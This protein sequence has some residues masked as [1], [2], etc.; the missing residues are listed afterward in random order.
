M[1]LLIRLIC[2]THSMSGI[3]VRDCLIKSKMLIKAWKHWLEN[4]DDCVA[5]SA[6][7]RAVEIGLQEIEKN[8]KLYKFPL[9]RA[10][11]ESVLPHSAYLPIDHAVFFTKVSAELKASD[12]LYRFSSPNVEYNI[13]LIEIDGS[14]TGLLAIAKALKDRLKK[15]G[16]RAQIVCVGM[17]DPTK[18]CIVL[19]AHNLQAM[20]SVFRTLYLPH[21][22]VIYNT[23]PLY[24]GNPYLQNPL[25]VLL[26][27][28][29]IWDTSFSSIAFLKEHGVS[30]THHV[31]I[32][33]EQGLID[34]KHM[35][36]IVLKNWEKT[37]IPEKEVQVLV[38]GRQTNRTM[39]VLLQLYDAGVRVKPI[40][41]LSGKYRNAAYAN[42]SILLYIHPMASNNTF[43][44]VLLGHAVANGHF[45]VSETSAEVPMWAG[46]GRVSFVEYD[47]L[48]KQVIWI[49]KNTTC[50]HRFRMAKTVR[51]EFMRT[52][53]YGP[54]LENWIS[55]HSTFSLDRITK[56]KWAALYVVF[57][58]DQWLAKSVESIYP[59]VDGILFL[60]GYYNFNNKYECNEKFLQ[61][62]RELPD[63]DHKIIGIYR[64]G[65]YP[66]TEERNAGIEM[67]EKL[68]FQFTYTIDADELL[69]T[70]D[71]K[72]IQEVLET[73][74]LNEVYVS[75]T[76]CYWKSE[77]YRIDPP[78]PSSQFL[79]GLRLHQGIKFK[80]IR[81]TLT[82]DGYHEI[83]HLKMH[84]MS[85]ARS[86][87]QVKKK[88][89]RW[90][91]TADL[92]PDWFD[93][94]WKAWD[95]DHSMENLHPTNPELYKRVIPVP[96]DELP[97][98]L[99]LSQDS[100][101]PGLTVLKEIS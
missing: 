62:L 64:K 88:L 33:F 82:P 50:D 29:E 39:H 100:H 52:T 32:A 34:E 85:Y 63:P 1:I 92:V 3:I 43:N 26:H 67:L 46:N 69:D 58:D 74:N 78:E 19:G 83:Q 37:P 31:P 4:K 44:G 94:V 91:H 51:K 101:R 93:N 98:V 11:T 15:L 40:F 2:Q 70:W 12:P 7:Q 21:D 60:V 54:C 35:K 99:R 10:I 81:H 38:L 79:V 20:E 55:R 5:V 90:S 53:S 59:Y 16:K 36:E 84:H 56:R 89:G 72:R 41:F 18:K 9:V 30:N 65:W 61:W 68:G 80:S 48:A 86:D 24:A 95:T 6:L 47:A 73:T 57:D 25:H 13:V 8:G 17:Q 45:V 87:E 77:N 97:E 27:E 42:S 66:E 71:A 22:A 75:K 28:H 76:L 14:E 49:L 96:P 23:E